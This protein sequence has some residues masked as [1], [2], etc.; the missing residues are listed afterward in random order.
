MGFPP[1]SRRLARHT[2]T[3]PQASKQV[4]GADLNRSESRAIWKQAKRFPTVE[5][6]SASQRSHDGQVA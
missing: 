3:L 5:A 2:L 4:L 6:K 1:L